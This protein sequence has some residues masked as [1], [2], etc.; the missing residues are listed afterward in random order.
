M[1]KVMIVD[2]EPLI[3]KGM[4]A[5]I[6]WKRHG[7]RIL[8]Q[9]ESGEEAIERFLEDPVDIIIT[10]I[11]MQGISG[12]QLIETVKS[13][14]SNAKFIV[15]SGYD[16][17]QYVKEGI[18][19]GIENYL[20][21]PI[22]VK[23]LEATLEAAV[24]KLEQDGLRRNRSAEEKQVLRNNVLNRWMSQSISMS[25]LKNRAEMIDLSLD[26]RS[27]A[28]VMSSLLRTEPEGEAFSQEVR[29]EMIA[30]LFNEVQVLFAKA[31]FSYTNMWFINQEADIVILF[32]DAGGTLKRDVL[33]RELQELHKVIME[34]WQVGMR[35]SI[36]PTVQNYAD[37]P[38]SYRKA[39]EQQ[40]R[41]SIQDD[42]M[43][44]DGDKP[45]SWKPNIELLQDRLAFTSL[46]AKR[47]REGIGRWIDDSFNRIKEQKDIS[48]A[49]I[50][51]VAMDLLIVI[52]KQVGMNHFM[53]TFTQL[54]RFRNLEQIRHFVLKYVDTRLEAIHFTDKNLSPIIR[55][56]VSDIHANYESELSLKTLGN[57][58]HVH[59]IY[60]G[61]L[62][63]KEM[64]IGFTNYINQ[65]RIQ[66]AKELLLNSDLKANEIARKIGYTD[67]NYFYKLFTKLVEVSPT[68]FRNLHQSNF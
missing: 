3:L 30:E 18:R 19:L 24:Q 22:D 56:M 44:L 63:K 1:Y 52:G 45:Y 53:E 66:I 5:I 50:Q 33:Y 37:V 25:E 41:S 68:H 62:F 26:E 21:K 48:L 28:V 34:R 13:L 64:G 40:M 61:Q 43:I 31:F 23:E 51:D 42:A 20:I 47:D 6:D 14:D 29:N 11:C 35:F 67:S 49:D 2:D 17:F 4:H 38:E 55:K 7:L 57:R 54:F 36:G 8:S 32:S 15:L 12:L 39:Q 60:L 10:D 58:Y 9:A 59:P 46:L 65:Y 16:D 27:Y